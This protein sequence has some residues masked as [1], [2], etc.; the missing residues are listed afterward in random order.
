MIVQLIARSFSSDGLTGFYNRCLLPPATILNNLEFELTVLC[1]SDIHLIR[2]C[3]EVSSSKDETATCAGC[4]R[5]ND[6]VLRTNLFQRLS[7][8]F[9]GLLQRDLGYV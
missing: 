5:S 6:L 4:F 2:T 9:D 3:T 8:L 7:L 1:Y